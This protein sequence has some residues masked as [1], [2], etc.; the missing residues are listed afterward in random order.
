MRTVEE[1]TM[2][3]YAMIELHELKLRREA[4]LA[5]LMP[6]GIK[7]REVDVMTS[8]PGDRLAE[9]MADLCDLEAD[10]TKQIAKI[11]RKQHA[12]QGDINRLTNPKYRVVLNRYY[13]SPD[14]PTVKQIG[15]ELGDSAQNVYTLRAKA[16][17]ALEKVRTNGTVN[18]MGL[19]AGG[20]AGT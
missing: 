17:K 15:A 6:S 1:L 19:D 20:H 4:L 9:V 7:P 8:G 10:I 14:M 5:S 18:N 12:L 13:M 16:I 2:C 3:R 11:A